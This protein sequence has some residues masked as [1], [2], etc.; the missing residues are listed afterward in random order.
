MGGDRAPDVVIGGA[1][2]AHARFPH[3]RFLLF[4][5]AARLEPLLA[6]TPKLKPQVEVRHTP[7]VIAPDEKP[8][9]A[10]R[11]G[12]NSSMRLAIDAVASGEASGVVSA[13]NTGALMATAKFVLKTLPGI[14]RPAITS[15][16]PTERGEIVMLDLG[17]NVECDADNLVQFAVMGANFAHSVLG[18]FRPT[19]GLLNVGVEEVKGH[20]VLK[21]A[22]EKLRATSD[23]AFDFSGFVEGDDIARGA[24]DV[25][26]TDGFTGNIALKT[27]EGT[28]RLVTGFVRTAF[29]GSWLARLGYLLARRPLR[30]VRDR[31]D[32]RLYNGGVFLG[33]N[34]IVVKSH[35]GTDTVGFAAAIELAVDMVA[36]RLTERI[37][38]DFQ[39]FLAAVSEATPQAAA[40]TVAS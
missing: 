15:F 6:R 9:I 39:R 5:D 21:A 3:V 38:A 19:V 29:E 24:V 8:S 12:R 30:A 7:D 25:I 11:R 14:D 18:R 17:A 10:L 28:A 32:P 2:Q 34:G 40:A 4:G 13:G 16:F 23:F 27:A 20:D 35:G 26:V 37:T 22:A 33:L 1:E 36:D 31:L